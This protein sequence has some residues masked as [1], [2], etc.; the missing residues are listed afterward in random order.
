MNANKEKNTHVLNIFIF[1][2]VIFL[3]FLAFTGEKSISDIRMEMAKVQEE[4][5]EKA[6]EAARR[7]AAGLAN[8]ELKKV[9]AYFQWDSKWADKSYANGNMANSGCGPTCMS[10]VVMYFTDDEDM[11]PAWMADFS[12]E[13]GY[14]MGGKTAWTMMHEGAEK[15]GLQVKEM[16]PNEEKMK[17]Q[18]D[19]ERVMIC[20]MRP[21]DF[22]KGGHFI[23]ITGYDEDGFTVRDPNSEENNEKSWA[24]D[25]I[26]WQI[27]NI[28][29]Y[30]M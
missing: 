28:W 8:H 16:S 5:E 22:T 30:W 25:R 4:Q 1:L 7:E 2:C 26:S 9:P 27:K 6:L 17:K 14:I 15:L 11:T 18:L 12:T 23:V 20:S 19:K 29:V 24:Y 3:V 21:G 13:N 10:M